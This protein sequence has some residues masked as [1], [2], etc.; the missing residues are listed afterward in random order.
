MT[1]HQTA[2]NTI[3]FKEILQKLIDKI[4]KNSIKNSLQNKLAINRI[5]NEMIELITISKVAYLV[6]KNSEN[7]RDIEEKLS[8]ILERPIR[9]KITFENKEE[10]F[11][12]KLWIHTP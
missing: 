2:E 5:T 11:T 8:E 4:N 1:E 9:I 10:Y 7:M 3:G 12:K 6:F